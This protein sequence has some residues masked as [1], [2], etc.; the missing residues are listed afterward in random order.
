V[1]TSPAASHTEGT[2]VTTPGGAGDRNRAKGHYV[3]LANRLGDES[4]GSYTRAS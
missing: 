4:A 3:T 2:Y 1:T